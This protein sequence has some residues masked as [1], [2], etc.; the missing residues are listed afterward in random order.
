MGYGVAY[1]YTIQPTPPDNY[2]PFSCVYKNI[3]PGNVQQSSSRIMNSGD[4]PLTWEIGFI[5]P[6]GWFQTAGGDVYSSAGIFSHQPVNSPL[7]YFSRYGGSGL[8]RGRCSM[9]APHRTTTFPSWAEQIK[10]RTA[11]PLTRIPAPDPLNWLANGLNPQPAQ[12]YFTYF[13]TFYSDH[14]NP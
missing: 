7:S 2:T 5:P 8:P 11:C 4:S 3:P 6:S 12:D 9:E 10:E 14:R 1:P 13:Y